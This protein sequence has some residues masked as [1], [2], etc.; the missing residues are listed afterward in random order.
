MKKRRNIL[1]ILLTIML[2]A[3]V[4]AKRKTLRSR[5]RKVK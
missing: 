4:T 2:V 3:G 5:S 1:V